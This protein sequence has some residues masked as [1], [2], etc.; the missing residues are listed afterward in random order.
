MY[1]SAYIAKWIAESNHP[2]TII[3]D[4]ELINLLTTGYP[5]LKVPSSNT[6]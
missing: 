6:V 3:S 5:H 2:A 1:I 4:P